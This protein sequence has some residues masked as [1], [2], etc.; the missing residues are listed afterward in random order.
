[1]N[2]SQKKGLISL[3]ILIS[4]S[5]GY[6]LL[7]RGAI[8]VPSSFLSQTEVASEPELLDLN[9]ADRAVLD[10]LPG[11]GPKLADR[12]VRYRELIGGYRS[13]RDL[14]NIKGLTAENLLVIEEHVTVDTT[15]AAFHRLKEL[16]PGAK[17]HF[18]TAYSP[19]QDRKKEFASQDNRFEEKKQGETKDGPSATLSA[20]D[21]QPAI[22][23]RVNLNTA[24]STELVKV[25]GIGAKTASAII[26]Y[27]NRLGFFASVD[28]L[29]E[30]KLI[31]PENYERMAPSLYVDGAALENLRTSI[32]SATMED[33]GKHP[34]IG[35]QIAKII[36]AF[37]ESHGHFAKWEDLEKIRETEA[38]QWSKLK[39]Y[40]HFGV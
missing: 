20:A 36:V 22:P 26:R 31:M 32:N 28:Q 35:W 2:Q 12:I 23:L 15:S 21:N 5:V 16:K 40:F 14:V 6:K 38:V 30:I 39:G 1:M 37:R 11:I 9:I 8:E 33:L 27:R 19:Q 25:K 29:L 24:D 4:L 17:A 3:L 7:S 10:S 18:F 13:V 34:Y